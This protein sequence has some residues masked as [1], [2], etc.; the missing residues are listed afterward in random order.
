MIAMH[1][2]D[3]EFAVSVLHTSGFKLL[4]QADLSR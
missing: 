4:Y 3:Y 1:V 2:E